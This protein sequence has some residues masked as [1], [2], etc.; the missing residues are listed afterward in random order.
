MLAHA[1][2][3]HADKKGR[4]TI[5]RPNAVVWRIYGVMTSYKYTEETLRA[6][7]EK[8]FMEY[9]ESH[10]SERFMIHLINRLR[11]DAK[12]DMLAGDTD[13]PQIA[14]GLADDQ[15]RKAMY[16]YVAWKRK[17]G[18]LHEKSPVNFIDSHVIGFGYDNDLIK[19]H[20]FDDAA[21]AAYNYRFGENFIKNYTL[22]VGTKDGQK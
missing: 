6:F 3:N 11:K 16:D 4:L 19:S 13:A 7:I 20:V 1:T 15:L 9:L 2:H 10:W 21:R 22:A 18:T 14:D 8:H 17:Q 5:R 12:L